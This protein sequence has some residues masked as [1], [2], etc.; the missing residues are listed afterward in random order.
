MKI[1]IT[2]GIGSGK[3]VVTAYLRSLG[4]TVICA[5]EVARQ[6]SEPGQ[7][8]EAAIRRLFGDGFFLPDGMLDRNKL[9]AEVFADSKKRRILEEALHPL[10]IRRVMSQAQSARGRVFVDAALLIQTGLHKSMDAVWLI[11][12]DH[13]IRLGRVMQRDGLDAQSVMQRME[14]Q[15]D[16]KWLA[17]FADEIITNDDSRHALYQ[18]IDTL[19]SKYI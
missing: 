13:H 1:G 5:D 16:D 11:T 9:G 17:G 19:L 2:G 6:V 18:R 14:S 4:E 7:P 10:I 8:G 15:P 3:S 12:A